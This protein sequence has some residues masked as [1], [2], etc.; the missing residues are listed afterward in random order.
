MQ[1]VPFF[2]WI[3]VL[4]QSPLELTNFETDESLTACFIVS[5]EGKVYKEILGHIEI[6]R[7]IRK[8]QTDDFKTCSTLECLI[9]LQG[10]RFN[11]YFF[12]KG[13]KWTI[14]AQKWH[15]IAQCSVEQKHFSPFEIL[16]HKSNIISKKLENMVLISKAC[17]LGKAFNY[18]IIR[19]HCSTKTLRYA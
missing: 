17:F 14:F 6:W 2:P 15:K 18:Y 16:S 11:L 13:L 5:F 4:Y 8:W 19:K 12:N 7:P 3:W 1:K 10:V 9:I